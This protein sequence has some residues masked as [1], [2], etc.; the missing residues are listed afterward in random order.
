M[1]DVFIEEALGIKKSPF[2]PKTFKLGKRCQK[3]LAVVGLGSNM[4]REMQIFNKLAI[5]LIKDSRLSLIKSSPVLINKAFGYVYQKD[6]FNAVLLIQTS[7]H[8]RAFL[9]L[10]LY[11]EFKF[12]RKRSFKNAPRTLDLDL[13]YF[14]KK[15]LNSSFCI[16]PHPGVSSRISVIL[17]LGMVI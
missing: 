9:K 2:Y 3:Y 15:S 16:L 5:L 8:A 4:G 14:S 10:L 13:L 1:Q 7:L 12:R 17:P 11:Y 6:F